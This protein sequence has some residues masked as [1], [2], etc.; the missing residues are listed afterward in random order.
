[1]RAQNDVWKPRTFK[2]GAVY[3]T[4]V[5]SES[6]PGWEEIMF[7]VMRQADPFWHPHPAQY[8]AL[9]LFTGVHFQFHRD[10]IVAENA[11]ELAL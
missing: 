6:D 10:S 3:V 11:E 5:M 7:L 4:Q 2:S 1:M 9:N 8:W